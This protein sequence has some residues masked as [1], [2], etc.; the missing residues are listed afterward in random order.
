MW[1]FLHFSFIIQVS[2]IIFCFC[3]LFSWWFTFIYFRFSL[4][5]C[6][7]PRP[8]CSEL[9]VSLWCF[10]VCFPSFIFPLLILWCSYSATR[11]KTNVKP[12]SHVDLLCSARHFSFMFLFVT[13]YHGLLTLPGFSKG[14][15]LPNRKNKR[16]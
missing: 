3:P 14:Y 12:V 16:M 15:V 4:Y 8:P 9:F 5:C 13:N 2:L 1:N 11:V 10:F 7:P 6:L